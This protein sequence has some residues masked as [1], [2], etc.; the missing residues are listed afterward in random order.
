MADDLEDVVD[1]VFVELDEDPVDVIEDEDGGATVFLDDEVVTPSDT[2]FLANL[3]EV[4]P[5]EELSSLATRLLDLIE[6]DKE[7]RQKRDR[8]QAEGLK[9]TGLGDDAPGGASFAG[10]SKIVHPMLIEACID[11]SGRVMKELFP[12]SGPVKDSIPGKLTQAKVAK[13]RRKT[14]LM[15]WQ[16]TTQ[17]KD[18]RAELEQLMTQV[19]MGGAQYMKLSWMADRNRPDFL[20][21]PIDEM[22]LPYA[23]TNFHNAE[24]KT[25]VQ[26]ITETEYLRR[27]RIGMYRDVDLVSPSMEPEQSQSA[28]ANDKIEGRDASCYNEDGLRT[29][30]E[31]FTLVDI[32]G[33]VSPY[34]VTVDETTRKVLSVYRN[35]AEDD[36]YQEE[37]QHFVEF[38]FIPWRGAYPLCIGQ[39]IGGMSGAAT[40]ALRGLLDSAHIN[41]TPSMIKLKGKVGGQSQAPQPGQA[42]EVEGSFGVDDIRKIAMPMPFNQPSPVLFELMQF[43]IGSAKNVVRT[44]LDEMP[45]MDADTPVGTTMARIEQGLTTFSAIHGRLHAAMAQLL[46]ILHRLN[47]Q[48]LDDENLKAEVG[49]A[50]ATRADFEGPIDVVP[51]SD[52]NIFSEVQRIAQVQTVERRM[53]QNPQAYD[54][55]KAEEYIL[56]ALKIPGGTDLLA[57]ALTPKEQNAVNENVAAS[58]GRPITAFPEQDHLAHLQTHIDYLMSPAF[59]TFSLIAPTFIPAV[60]NHVKEHVALWYASAVFQEA[61][62][63]LGTDLGEFMR[64]MGEEDDGTPETR[65]QMDMMLAQASTLALS[66]GSQLFQQLPAVIQQAQRIMQQYQQQPPMDPLIQLE[67]KKIDSKTQVDQA[68]L[69]QQSADSAAELAFREKELAVDA[70]LRR[71]EI[72][73]EDGRNNADNATAMDLAVLKLGDSR[74]DRLANERVSLNPSPNP[75]P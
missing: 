4:L 31:I 3:A 12:A 53:A 72:A 33:E 42:V 60:L 21:V 46:A 54:S 69:Q 61:S 62:G 15:N 58:L 51:V 39:I 14:T 23:A 10:A 59:G 6:R 1:G 8:D 35:W 63:A 38:P 70:T 20:F 9:R 43:V 13:A 75:Q 37:L 26:Y 73:G 34:I 27:V 32:E 25:H 55:R 24:R 7:A 18:F 47:G 41:N 29:V 5:E 56:S 71:E 22:Y 36:D 28:M 2:A 16:L 52:P 68:K 11:F 65:R 66:E 40:G 45:D 17:C 67:N 19:P 48:Y 57:P 30:F 44:S 49:E 50:L 74:E 64:V